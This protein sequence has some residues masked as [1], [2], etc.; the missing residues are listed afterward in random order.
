MCFQ[1]MILVC[2]MYEL[3]MNEFSMIS[4]IKLWGVKFVMV[5]VT[6]GELKNVT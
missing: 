5:V 3:Q 6:N 1:C 2:E 4:I